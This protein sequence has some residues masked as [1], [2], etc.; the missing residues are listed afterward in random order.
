MTFL[1]FTAKIIS[2]NSLTVCIADCDTVLKFVYLS[3]AMNSILGVIDPFCVKKFI[4]TPII[5]C[6]D[7]RSL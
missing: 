5:R 6:I 2:P 7:F 1:H 4:I 3:T